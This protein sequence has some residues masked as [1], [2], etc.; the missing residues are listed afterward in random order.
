[1][2]YCPVLCCVLL[3]YVML[4][5]VLTHCFVLCCIVLFCVVF[6]RVLL[7]C[8]MLRVLCSIVLWCVV[9]CRLVLCSVV[10]LLGAVLHCVM[11]GCEQYIVVV[12]ICIS[13]LPA[14]QSYIIPYL[15][16]P[17][18]GPLYLTQ[19]SPTEMLY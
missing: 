8:V 16:H 15:N 7:C 14:T 9:M 6:N 13:A 12:I 10:V 4:C 2:F 5:S 18:I 19:T 11:L 3:C 1:M 17:V